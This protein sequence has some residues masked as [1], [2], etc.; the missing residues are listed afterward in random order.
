MHASW[1]GFVS[2][3]NAKDGQWLKTGDVIL[4]CRDAELESKI[5][6]LKSELAQA[7]LPDDRLVARAFMRMLCRRPT[8]TETAAA[9]KI[10]PKCKTREEWV[11]D[12]LWALVA[13]RE[14]LFIS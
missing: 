9:L 12:L 6:H 3:I 14:F 4:V 13:S 1:P 7:K 8:A 11:Q 2:Q 5:E 10:L